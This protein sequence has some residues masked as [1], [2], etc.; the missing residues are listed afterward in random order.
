MPEI[1]ITAV[2]RSDFGKGAARRLRRDGQVPAVIYG[3][4]TELKHVALPAHE[5]NLAL[6]KPGLVLDVSF[7]GATT[8]VA[9][10]DVQRDPIRRIVEHIDLVII[11]KAEQAARIEEGLVLEA[12]LAEAALHQEAPKGDMPLEDEAP[13]T[14]AEAPES[15]S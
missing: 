2:P 14:D 3:K 1:A 11:D 10:R 13:V 6:R 9:P 15:D 4:G 12:E 8:I 5:L 7:E